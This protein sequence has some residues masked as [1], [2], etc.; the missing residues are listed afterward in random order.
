MPMV[1]AAWNTQIY[2]YR[3]GVQRE[4]SKASIKL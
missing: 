4:L 3:T 2:N 1:E